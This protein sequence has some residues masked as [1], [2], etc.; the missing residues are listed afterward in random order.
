M[1]RRFR[2][3][4]GRAFSGKQRFFVAFCLIA[5]LFGL[6]FGLLDSRVRPIAETLAL[7]ELDNQVTGRINAICEQLTQEGS[8]SYEE[9]VE[10]H[11]DQN[12]A[13]SDLTTRMEAINLLRMAVGRGV[14]EVLDGKTRQ[15]IKIP[16]GAVL[17]WNLFTALGPEVAV[18]L[19]HTGQVS[20][21]FESGFHT[22]GIDQTCHRINMVVSVEVLL[23]LP[24]G[25]S[26]QTLQCTVP[27]A[28]GLFVGQIPNSYS[29]LVY[30]D[31]YT[32]AVSDS[33]AALNENR[34]GR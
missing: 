6:F 16:I 12:G 7:A 23:M 32:G 8:L 18:Q 19:L 25:I 13:V 30:G 2:R 9:L 31:Q 4:I 24:G 3:P 27:L 28:E 14:S 10:V 15:K 26:P 20:I 33:S 34:T 21:H 5:L 17:H 1:P 29:N 11:Y 22:V